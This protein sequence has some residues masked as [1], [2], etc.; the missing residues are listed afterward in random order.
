MAAA[1][2][3]MWERLSASPSG[4]RW[5]LV[6]DRALVGTVMT[7]AAFMLE[8]AVLRSTRRARQRSSGDSLAAQVRLSLGDP[9]T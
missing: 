2:P 3:S 1:P 9:K 6:A 7:A 8:R 4:R 5:V